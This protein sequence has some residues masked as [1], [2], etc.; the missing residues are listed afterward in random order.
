MTYFTKKELEELLK[1]YQ[2]GCYFNGFRSGLELTKKIQSMIN[3][4]CEPT[5]SMIV[6]QIKYWNEE[7]TKRENSALQVM[8]NDTN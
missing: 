6:A 1:G 8:L 7:L 2:D 4:Y 5:E 3:N